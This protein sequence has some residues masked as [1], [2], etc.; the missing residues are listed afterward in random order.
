MTIK[1]M[2]INRV[3]LEDIIKIIGDISIKQC[4]PYLEDEHLFFNITICGFNVSTNDGEVIFCKEDK[5]FII[6]QTSFS[7]IVII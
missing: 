3:M 2:R 4:T 6:K 7:G 5:N 1:I